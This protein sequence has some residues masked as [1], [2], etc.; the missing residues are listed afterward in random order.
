MMAVIPIIADGFGQS[1]SV[2]HKNY[3]IEVIV[4]AS[5]RRCSNMRDLWTVD[6][7]HGK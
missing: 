4:G 5:A 1:H 2:V 3:T 7:N 6:R